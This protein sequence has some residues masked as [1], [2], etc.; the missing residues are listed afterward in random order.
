MSLKKVVKIENINS[1]NEIESVHLNN[2]KK[3]IVSKGLFSVGDDGYYF[4]NG[5]KIKIN[6]EYPWSSSFLKVK[7]N[8]YKVR[9]LKYKGEVYDGLLMSLKEKSTEFYDEMIVR[10]EMKKN[11]FPDFI[12]KY[13]EFRVRKKEDLLFNSCDNFFQKTLKGFTRTNLY[14]KK[15]MPESTTIICYSR[16]NQITGEREMGSLTKKSVVCENSYFSKI[17]KKE[18]ILGKIENMAIYGNIFNG[19]IY[20]VK[21]YDLNSECFYTIKD[22][23]NYCY[24]NG[25]EHGYI[26]I[27]ENQ[28]TKN[29]ISEMYSLFNEYR[30]IEDNPNYMVVA[31]NVGDMLKI[32]KN[33]SSI[34]D[35]FSWK[36]SDFKIIK[37]VCCYENKQSELMFDNYSNN[38]EFIGGLCAIVG[39]FSISMIFIDSYFNADKVRIS[40]Q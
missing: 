31:N 18:K 26:A 4:E 11:N 9:S 6:R 25:L 3:C 7:K 40:F 19:K 38:T 10:R 15:Y 22:L 14:V 37:G 39:L 16:K 12:P 35:Y 13:K 29:N 27:Y 30:K 2:G 23:I 8:V 24:F 28:F 17:I 5:T 33:S 36:D 32:I 34:F 20:V 1:M 21:I